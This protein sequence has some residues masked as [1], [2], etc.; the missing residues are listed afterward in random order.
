MAFGLREVVPHFGLQRR[1]GFEQAI[2][3]R[4]QRRLFGELDGRKRRQRDGHRRHFGIVDAVKVFLDVG[5]HRLIGIQQPVG[6]GSIGAQIVHRLEK[7]FAEVSATAA[8]WLV[9]CRRAQES[10][11][12]SENPTTTQNAVVR[13]TVFSSVDTVRRFNMGSPGISPHG[14]KLVKI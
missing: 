8:M 2:Q 9:T 11:A 7:A 5:V 12:L 4:H 6:G 10:H 3:L 13:M 1:Q 14:T